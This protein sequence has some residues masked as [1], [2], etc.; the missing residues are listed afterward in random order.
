MDEALDEDDG[1][2]VVVVAV[3]DDGVLVISALKYCP[4]LDAMPEDESTM[5]EDDALNESAASRINEACV[6]AYKFWNVL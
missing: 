1:M 5:D 3:N 6:E 2:L 4:T